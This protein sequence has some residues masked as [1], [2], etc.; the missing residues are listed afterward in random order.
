MY[1]SFFLRLLNSRC[2]ALTRLLFARIVD[3]C[4]TFLRNWISTV[5][6]LQMFCDNEMAIYTSRS[7]CVIKLNVVFFLFCTITWKFDTCPR[8][9]YDREIIVNYPVAWKYLPQRSRSRMKRRAKFTG[10]IPEGNFFA[11][12]CRPKRFMLARVF[13][14][15]WGFK[16]PRSRAARFSARCILYKYP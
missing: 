1:T 10:R 8:D 11:R 4:H 13:E 2:S 3:T 12:V 7:E 15:T 9:G 14:F 16:F 6:Q 5:R